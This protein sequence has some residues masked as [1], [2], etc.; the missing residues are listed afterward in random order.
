VLQKKYEEFQKDLSNHEDQILELNR[1]ADE[2]VSDGHPD[3]TQIRLKQKEVNDAW[4]RLRSNASQR[5]ERL[6]GAHEVQ[7]LNRDIDEAISWI[8]EKESII[9][10]DDYGKDLANVQSLQRKHDAVERDLAALAD[11][12]D[13]LQREG[14]RLSADNPTTSE[15]LNLK[16]DE[17][18]SHWSNLKQKAQLRKQRLAESYKLQSFLSDHRDLTNW[19]NEMSAV[20]S[21]EEIAKDVSSAESLI[22]RHSE[23]KS[24]LESR[25]DSLSKTLKN[26]QELLVLSQE[27]ADS[28]S[29]LVENRQTISER[30]EHLRSERERLREVWQT[31]QAFFLQSLDFQLF[32]RD[33][34][35][36]DTWIT[37]QESF[38]ANDS[39][40]ESLDDVEAL[41]KKHEDFEKSLAAQEEK[42][43]YLEDVSDR[44]INGVSGTEKNYA[45]KEIVQKRDYLRE[46]R[47]LMQQKADQRRIL[48]Q[49]CLNLYIFLISIFMK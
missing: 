4:N 38:L 29:T 33:A 34:E 39:L 18:S 14:Q 6:F 17:I 1:R 27:A 42:A 40:G 26:G 49:V 35:Q 30:L 44:L 45:N 48:L 43:K 28:Q 2:L 46:R 15:Q 13:G 8:N 23:H 19:Y 7:R 21:A 32:M 10:T 25:D 12:V 37:K 11:K 47:A 36:A 5:Q 24:E 31:K 41:I 9:S 16:L 22:E 20:M 3:V